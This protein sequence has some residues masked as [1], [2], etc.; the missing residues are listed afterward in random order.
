MK[1]C[2]KC[3]SLLIKKQKNFG[4]SRCDYI[5]KEEIS[6]KTNE[7][8]KERNFVAVIDQEKESN[9]NP[10]TDFEC[11]RCKN[12]KAYFWTQQMRAGDEPESKFYRCT[13]CKTVTRVD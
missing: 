5:T 2:P 4:C 11:P 9:I 13:K 1:F 6:I 8:S 3:G 12:D 10:I 7:E